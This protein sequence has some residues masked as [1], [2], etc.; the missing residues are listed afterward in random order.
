MNEQSQQSPPESIQESKRVN[1]EICGSYVAK[2][3]IDLNGK[4]LWICPTD[5]YT[6]LRLACKLQPVALVETLIFVE[7]QIYGREP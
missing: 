7:E 2:L 3:F 1:C 5:A 6:L 4:R